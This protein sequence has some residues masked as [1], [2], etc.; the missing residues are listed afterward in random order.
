MAFQAFGLSDPGC[1]RSENQDRILVAPDLGLFAVCDG[2]GGHACGALAAEM[3]VEA[4]SQFVERSKGSDVT[5]PFGFDVELSTNANRLITAI[6]LANSIIWKQSE[7]SATHAGM[8]S[9]VAAVLL[10]DSQATVANVGDS[11]VSLLREKGL[12]QISKDHTIVASLVEQGTIPAAAARTHPMRNVLLQAAGSSGNVKVHLFEQ[13]TEPGDIF[14]L[15]SDGLHGVV[16]EQAICD[17]L[18]AAEDAESAVRKLVEMA[19]D[20]GGPDNISVVVVLL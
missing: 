2:M 18:L 12:K 16:D 9:T 14:L 8:G 17:T 20:A 6:K 5:W 19:R 15:S 1:L 13:A 7:H 3:A 4:I 10:D 11:R